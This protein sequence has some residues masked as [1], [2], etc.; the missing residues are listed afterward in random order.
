[1]TTS[2]NNLDPELVKNGDIRNVADRYRCWTN[3][4][5]KADMQARATSLEIAIENLT[6]DFNMGTVVRNANAFNVRRVHIIGR[7][8][9]NKRGAMV[10]NRYLEV[11][12]HPTV[13]DFMDFVAE[14]LADYH[15]I[16]IDNQTGAQDL[17]KFDLPEKSLL[18]F[19][20]ESDGISEE[21][22][23]KAEVMVQIEQLGSTRSVN[24]GVASGIVMYEWTR[25]F[26]FSKK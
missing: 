24:V 18:I 20:S 22:L 9:W 12:H 25:R 15:L 2:L 21:L 7:K 10:T 19:G 26:V 14:N 4:A 16:A 5:I 13:G 23:A 3:E 8:Q 6:H 17:A 1:M 11:I